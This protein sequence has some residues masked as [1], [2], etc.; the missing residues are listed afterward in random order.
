[1]A[2]QT[3]P[4]IWTVNRLVTALAMGSDR[5]EIVRIP[6]FQRPLVWNRDKQEKL[7]ES[8]LQGFPIGTLL[9]WED[10]SKPNEFLLVDGQQRSATL[11]IHSRADLKLV[12]SA[13]VQGSPTNALV[14]KLNDRINQSNSGKVFEES[15]LL[16]EFITWLEKVGST[17]AGNFHVAGLL[18]ALSV[19]QTLFRTDDDSIADAA[20]ELVRS[21]EAA[22]NVANLRIPVLIYRGPVDDLDNIFV[23]IN[24][25]GVALTK[26]QVW[27]ALWAKD[28]IADADTVIL[29][30]QGNRQIALQEKGLIYENEGPTISV[31]LFEYLN[32]AGHV[33]S[34]RHSDLFPR[35]AHPAEQAYGFSI[36]ALY[37]GLDLSRKEAGKLPGAIQNAGANAMDKF[38]ED[39]ES[40]CAIVSKV[41]REIAPLRLT[42]SLNSLPHPEL[43]MV[44]LVAWVTHELRD[45]RKLRVADHKAIQARYVLDLLTQPF[46]GPGDSLACERVKAVDRAGMP[47]FYMHRPE[48]DEFRRGLETWVS[49]DRKNTRKSRPITQDGVKKFLLRAVASIHVNTD[50]Q[51]RYSFDIDHIQALNSPLFKFPNLGDDEVAPHE[52]GNLCLLEHQLNLKKSNKELG[53]FLE[54]LP[55]A[56]KSFILRVGRFSASDQNN[57]KMAASTA[58]EYS[59]GTAQRASQ[60]MQEILSRLGY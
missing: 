47:N 11:L 21:I 6:R 25:Q 8:V 35:L 3:S 19:D 17:S 32:A 46:R 43:Q 39:L 30:E 5:G 56:D 13:G 18:K 28:E 34:S 1:M 36:A 54:T 33:I 24:Q 29:Q 26:Y 22:V 38:F 40:A 31:N 59:T 20:N 51:Q 2:G 45:G 23:N 58:K 44:A 4:E 12:T 57:F 37:F 41:L 53:T 14:A 16:E 60:L 7:I 52:L 9:L 49:E 27:A 42:D 55:E 10:P 48:P 50:E 15:A